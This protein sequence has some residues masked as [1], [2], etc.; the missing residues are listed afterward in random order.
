MD[1][2]VEVSGVAN[3]QSREPEAQKQ[4]AQAQNGRRDYQRP[5]QGLRSADRHGVG[6]RREQR[7]VGNR[8]REAQLE[9]GLGPPEVARLAN[10]QLHQACDAVLYHLATASSLIEDRAGLQL[11]RLLEQGFL[12]MDLYRPP[13]LTPC[14]LGSKWARCT[15]LGG[16]HERST[17]A[18]SEPQV[19]RGLLIRAGTGPSLQIDLKRGLGEQLPVLDLWHLG[20]DRPS[21]RREFRS[22]TA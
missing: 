15:G 12:W 18:L 1:E 19:T 6:R 14:A 5:A 13:A 9:H 22:R 10:A 16:K 11:T 4:A 17:S 8:R 2:L 3:N 7:Q 21:S 20:D